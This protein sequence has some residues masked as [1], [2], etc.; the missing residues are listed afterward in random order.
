MNAPPAIDM[1]S[2]V[3]H[4]QSNA[5][6]FGNPL[7]AQPGVR[8][9][10]NDPLI[11]EDRRVN[12]AAAGGT[13]RTMGFGAAAP[14]GDRSLTNAGTHSFIRYFERDPSAR[15]RQNT[16]DIAEIVNLRNRT[17]TVDMQ[18]YLSWLRQ[19]GYALAGNAGGI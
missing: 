15:P 19:H 13:Q 9:A 5:I 18:A 3:I 17:G 7:T 16:N 12:G 6:R 4:D 10:N 8:L 14:G 2:P 1:N 11:P